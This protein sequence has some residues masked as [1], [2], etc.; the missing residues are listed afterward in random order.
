MEKLINQKT[1][2]ENGTYFIGYASVRP[3]LYFDHFHIFDLFCISIHRLYFDLNL[4]ST[5]LAKLYFDLYFSTSKKSRFEI[6]RSTKVEV[7]R[8]KYRKGRRY[9]NGRSTEKVED[10]KMVEVQKKSN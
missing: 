8:S 3:L 9:E 1:S 4:S 7:E 6:G 2:G 5:F 10:M